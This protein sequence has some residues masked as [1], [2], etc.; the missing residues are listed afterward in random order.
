M[1]DSSTIA[2]FAAATLALLIVPGPSVL[3]V[4]TRS[5]DGGRTAGLLSVL[6]IHTGPLVHVAAAAFGLSALLM[7]SALAFNAV[8]FAGWRRRSLPSSGPRWR[9][10]RSSGFSV[11]GS[12]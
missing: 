2:V 10:R 3:Y 9:P 4:V 1:P 6:G 5:M 12:W 7:T 8:K 11:R